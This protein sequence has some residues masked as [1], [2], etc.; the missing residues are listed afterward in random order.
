MRADRLAVALAALVAFAPLV[1]GCY[2]YVP[3]GNADLQPDN[4]VRVRVNEAEAR[5]LAVAIEP[6]TRVLEGRVVEHQQDSVL[7]LVNV[8]SEL[9]GARV[10]TLNQRLNVARPGIVDVELRQLDGTKTAIVAVAGVALVGTVIGAIATGGFDSGND[11][12]GP[13]PRDLLVPLFR[14]RW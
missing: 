11:D 13:G 3:A 8:Y 9:Q 1:A 12:G 5:R 7:L 4:E 10:V 6:G 14:L 2:R